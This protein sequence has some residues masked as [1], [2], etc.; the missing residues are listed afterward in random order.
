MSDSHGGAESGPS[1]NSLEFDPIVNGVDFLDS[2]ISHLAESADPRRLKYAVLHLQAAIE[3]LVKVRLQREGIE[4]IFEDPYSA[5]ENKLRQGAFRSVTLNAAIKRLAKVAGVQLT[6]TQR[7]ALDFLNKER[8]KLQ[9]FGSTSNHEVVTARAAAALDVLSEFIRQHLVPDAPDDEIEH[10][11]QAEE[12]IG[13]A[14]TTIAAVNRARLDRLA[15][16]LEAWPSIVIH[17]PECMQVAWTFAPFEETSR[18]LFCGQDW[19]QVDG[20][21]AAED[22]VTSVLGESRYLAAK[23]RSGWSISDCPEC[24]LEALIAVATRTDPNSFLTHACFYCGFV[25]DADLGS[26]GRCGRTTSD[27]DDVICTDC[28]NDLVGED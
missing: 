2:A 5:D 9:H 17:C 3:I 23:G 4:H 20:T 26:C 16:E 21:D 10:L 11:E 28:L 14:L 6:A 27:P 7:D 1:G 18:C 25:T 15:P 19:S 12:I 24:E 8:N 13:A 22:Y